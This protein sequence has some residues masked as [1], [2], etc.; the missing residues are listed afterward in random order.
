MSILCAP[1]YAG[2]VCQPMLCMYARNYAMHTRA[3]T[4]PKPS[5]IHPKYQAEVSIERGQIVNS[6]KRAHIHVKTI[7]KCT[8][9]IHRQKK[10]IAWMCEEE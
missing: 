2:F 10:M 5:Q 3:A 7:Q 9:T 6:A 1:A 4:I 8:R